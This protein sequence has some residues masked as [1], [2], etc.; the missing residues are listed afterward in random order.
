MAKID[1]LLT[2]GV[3]VTQD[4]QRRVIQDGAVAIRGDRIVAVGTTADLAARFQPAEVVDLSGQAVFPGLINT[5]THLFQVSVKGLGEDMPVQ[6]WVRAVTAPTAIH[7]QPDE[8]YLFGLTGCLEQ[9]RS[10]VTTLVDMSY[11]AYTFALHEANIRAISDSGLRGRYSSIISDFGEEYGVLPALIKPIER[12]LGE[13]SELLSRYPAGDRMGIWLAIGAPWT[14]TDRGMR[15]TRAFADRTGTRLVMHVLEN[16]VD[17]LLCR[18]RNGINI[19]PYLAETGFLGPDLLAIHCVAA[20]DTD[21]ALFARHG[22][23]VSYNPVSNMY[24]G[25]GIPPMMRMAAAGLTIG[26]G[27]D[28]AGSNN[29][30]DMIESLKFAAL[31]QK[32]AARDA[33]VVYA[34]TI[35][36]WATRGGAEILGLADEIGSLEASK[37]ADLFVLAARSPKIVPAH[38]PVTTLVYSAGE[39][40]VTMTVA[41]GKVLMRDG[42]IQHLDERDLLARCQAAALQLADRCGSN[43]RVTRPWRPRW[44]NTRQI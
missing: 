7:I 21:I 19:V 37:K 41:E 26:I 24:L 1:L 17:N 34:Q 18:Q 9:I 44:G 14:V 31:L 39:G 6:D 20:D 12:F 27:T 23:K 25:S 11:A 42:V 36:D 15:E 40:D 8:M 13:Y 35:L 22:V 30:Q 4:D 3:I 29:S 10:G 38:D 5:H 2:H 33:S 28:G 32:V 16:A 43:G